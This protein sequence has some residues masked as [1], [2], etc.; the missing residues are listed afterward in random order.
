MEI[1]MTSLTS[2]P[3]LARAFPAV[4]RA[5]EGP[6]NA[7]F[8]EASYGH[9]LVE[10]HFCTMLHL[11]GQLMFGEAIKYYKAC[12]TAEA[13]ARIAVRLPCCTED[14]VALVAPSLWRMIDSLG[15]LDI[16]GFDHQRFSTDYAHFMI[17]QGWVAPGA[18]S[19]LRGGAMTDP[20]AP[21]TI[22]VETDDVL[23]A[24]VPR[25][26]TVR[27]YCQNPASVKR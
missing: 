6:F 23:H 27:G 9:A 4:Q 22:A 12:H 17:A 3:K 15:K 13:S 24:A 2:E 21:E 18:R 14:M 5:M 8:G 19:S 25:I 10:L 1:W 20:R 16:A 11:P 7:Y 26:S